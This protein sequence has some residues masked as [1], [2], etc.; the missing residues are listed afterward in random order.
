[1]SIGTALSNA[2]SGL[3]ASS[4]MAEIIASNVANALNENYARR[5]VELS[6]DTVAGTGAGVRIDGI[7]RLESAVA[8]AARRGA[9]A[10]AGQSGT[11]ATAYDRMELS[12]GRAE[13]ADSLA[14]RAI[15]LE[16]ALVSAAATPESASML[17]NVLS[18][19]TSVVDKISGISTEN[20]RIRMD[21]DAEIARQIEVVNT[22]LG[23]IDQINREI[24]I[25]IAGGND[26]AALMDQRKQLID[27]VSS[28]IPI[29]TVRREDEQIALFS[30]KGAQLLDG[31]VAV[32]AFNPAVTITSDM[33]VGNGSLSGL[34]LDGSAM[35]MGD[36][37]GLLE[38]G[39]LAAAFTVRDLIVPLADRKLDAF[40][41]DLIARFESASIDPTIT[42]GLPGL[43]TDAGNTLSLPDIEGLASR[44]AV[45]AQVDPGQGGE[46]WRL[47]DGLYAAAPGNA[48]NGNILVAMRDRLRLPTVLPI[49]AGTSRLLSLNGFATD[50]VSQQGATTLR[51]SENAAFDSARLTMF[52]E[53]EQA[54]TGV[55]TD[56]EMQQLMLVEQSYAANARVVSVIDGLLRTLMEM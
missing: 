11:L 52:R 42:V 56:F 54:S 20:Q 22:A 44:L 51:G 48:G 7:V 14:A 49:G 6:A 50:I 5:S 23:D 45:N 12:L 26:A 43:F 30:V 8:T 1:M 46:I 2:Y 41:A 35:A 32:L 3:T 21:A 29:R 17:A 28:I 53:A 38:G 10:G 15:A 24:Q 27:K 39:S 16:S 37:S 9:E 47:R 13:D 18:A 34:T 55:N 4:R 36:G 25:Q 33:N 19:A 31:T 40:A